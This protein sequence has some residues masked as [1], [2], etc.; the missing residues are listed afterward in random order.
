MRGRVRAGL[1]GFALVAAGLATL[2]GGGA[3]AAAEEPHVIGHVEADEFGDVVA[4]LEANGYAMS[5]AAATAGVRFAGF[6]PVSPDRVL[7][8]RPGYPGFAGQTAIGPDAS[9][10]VQVA[11]RAGVPADAGAVVLNVTVT[12]P[13]AGGYLT[14]WPTGTARPDTSS[15]NMVAGQTVPN[16]VVVKLGA[17]G[18]VSIYNNAG[19]SDVLVDVVGW[20]RDDGHFVGLT[21]ARVL[22]TRSGQ[23]VGAGGTLDVRV[24]GLGGVPSTGV[25]T[26]VLNVTA[27]QPTSNSYLTVWPTGSPQPNASSVNMSAGQTVP[28]LVYASVGAD[29]RVSFFNERGTTH[30]LVDVVGYLPTGAAYIPLNPVRVMDTRTGVGS[31]GLGSGSGTLAK[32][33]GKLGQQAAWNLDVSAVL[34]DRY[35]QLTSSTVQALVLN[36]TALDAT[37]TSFLTVYPAGEVRPN[38]SNVNMVPDQVVANAVVVKAGAF[39]RVSIYNHQGATNVIVDIVGFVPRQNAQDTPDGVAG[40]K[41]HVVYVQG[42]NSNTDPAYVQQQMANIRTEVEAL[43]GWFAFPGQAGRHLNIDRANSQIEVSYIKYDRFTTDQ[44][45]YWNNDFLRPVFTQ[46]IDDGFGSTFGRLWLVYFDGN[47]TDGVCGIASLQF[48][49]V[50]MQNLC[51]TVNGGVP[52]AAVG[53]SGNTAQVALHEM[54]HGLGAVPTCS[55]HADLSTDGQGRL[56]HP[57]HVTD[58]SDLM[59]WNTGGQP[60]Q[61]DIGRDDYFGPG[62]NPACVDIS[63]S[64]FL[65]AP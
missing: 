27:T 18:R 12:G 19:Q 14:V 65:A 29:G 57:G 52:A 13:T 30:L 32:P 62:A 38:A 10:D 40:S 41:Y 49:T 25:G 9:I 5:P 50:F 16:A 53:A 26:V 2:P 60:K 63:K 45:V 28:N 46:L 6:N 24:T 8:T 33:S 3:P 4:R 51:G 43:D 11:G 17:G 61:L 44:L 48:T 1:V 56:L 22:D 7:E 35:I 34:A 36:V 47:R 21:P 39:N 20:S 59:Y 37:A 55:P 64:P 42:S 31:Y 23:P 58:Q 15:L 54:L